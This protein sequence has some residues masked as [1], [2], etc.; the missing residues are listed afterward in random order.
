MA[1]ACGESDGGLLYNAPPAP[2][3]LDA[4]GRRGSD[5]RMLEGIHD[6]VLIYNPLAGSQRKRRKEQLEAARRNL[7][8]AG[9]S[10]ELQPTTAAGEAT[11]LAQ[12]AVEQGRQLVIVCGGDGT[13]NEAVN[14]LA[15]SR[16]PLAVLPAGT[17][18]VLAKELGLPWSIARAAELV[19]GSR[20]RRV[21]LGELVPAEGQ[22]RRHFLC[23]AGAG[24]DGAIVHSLNQRLKLRA[25]IAAY[26]VEGLRQVL[27][28]PFPRFRVR[29]AG[30]EIVSTLV[31]VGRTKHYGGPFRITTGADLFSNHFELA[32]VT[33]R[34]AVRYV[35]YLPRLWFD[36]LRGVR[37][38][39][40]CKTTS[41]RCEPADEGPILAQVDGEPWG[42]LPAEFR[43]VPDALT[44]AVPEP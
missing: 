27:R 38:V 5:T 18:N 28:Y 44:L 19:A 36:R 37:G 17:A 35:S 40:F 34:S 14:G 12:R 25:G 3:P 10:A 32:I 7:G 29:T 2:M 24:P 23:V 4:A 21:A 15:G 30:E 22:P 1:S 42:R 8:R 11:T 26:W 33:T 41:L 13:I 9:I 31:V 16:V 43:I 6:A 39:Y 20:L